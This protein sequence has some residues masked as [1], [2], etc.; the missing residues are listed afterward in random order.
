MRLYIIRHAEPA[1]P[2][3]ALTARGH[4]QAQDLAGRLAAAGVERVYSSPLNRAVETARPTAERLGVGIGVEPWMREIEH[5]WIPGGPEGEWP[6]WQVDGAAVRGLVPGLHPENWHR[7]PPFD[8]PVLRQGFA[9]LRS[10]SAAFLARHGYVPEG[11][12]YRVEPGAGGRLA[13]FCH[14]GFGLTWLAHLLE[15]AP[16]LVWA[17]FALPSASVTTVDFEALPDGRAA[18]RCLGLGDL[19]HERRSLHAPRAGRSERRAR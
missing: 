17:G 13:V 18:P 2:E 11:R 6:V 8:L 19:S 4:R 14:A 3:D 15:I 10:G 1:Y 5:W 7:L 16:P 12:H 9:E